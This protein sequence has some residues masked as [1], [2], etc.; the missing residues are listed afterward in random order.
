MY[1]LTAH[2]TATAVTFRPELKLRQRALQ[3]PLRLPCSSLTFRPSHRPINIGMA[4]RL[5]LQSPRLVPRSRWYEMTRGHLGSVRFDLGLVRLV[6]YELPRNRT[7]C[8]GIVRYASDSYDSTSKCAVLPR[9]GCAGRYAAM[10]P[11]SCHHM[12]FSCIIM[13]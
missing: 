7:I 5:V 6:R 8:L 4:Q 10:A 11:L 12:A 3:T 2:S 9:M 13:T 1:K